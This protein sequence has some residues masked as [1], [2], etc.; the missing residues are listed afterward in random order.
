MGGVKR[1][2]EGSERF[3]ITDINNPNSSAKGQSEINVMVDTWGGPGD[4]DFT[5]TYN[6]IPGGV[7]VRYM[8]GHVSWAKAKAAAPVLYEQYNGSGFPRITDAFT[9]LNWPWRG[10]HAPTVHNRVI[11]SPGSQ[12]ARDGRPR[13][14]SRSV[15]PINR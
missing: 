5:T 6:H 11:T 10:V 3:Q 13:G 2:R 7:N 4:L 8:D 1:L 12:P 9:V 14:N 15:H